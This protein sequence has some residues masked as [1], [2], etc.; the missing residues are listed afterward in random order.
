MENNDTIIKAK[1]LPSLFLA[2]F[3]I[4]FLFA[5]IYCIILPAT[6]T[7]TG[8][9]A[10]YLKIVYLVIGCIGTAFFGYKTTFHVIKLISPPKSVII[11]DEGIFD[12]TIPDGGIA[13]V[14]WDNIADI[15]LFGDKKCDWLGISLRTTKKVFMGLTKSAR[16]EISDNIDAGMPAIIIKAND[17][18]IDIYELRDLIN[19]RLKDINYG[20]QTRVMHNKPSLSQ[21][22]GNANDKATY[23]DDNFII[24]P[25]L[26]DDDEYDVNETTA[27]LDP[28]LP[29][30]EEAQAEDVFE[31]DDSDMI[32]IEDEKE[33]DLEDESEAEEA[34]QEGDD[35]KEE[36]EQKKNEKRFF[37]S[38]RPTKKS[39][40]VK[41]E[42][43]IDD[44]LSALASIHKKEDK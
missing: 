17:I 8:S 22:Y 26:K 16:N 29:N 10:I 27:I 4:I 7:L 37:E 30:E 43:N 24:E 34:I 12:Y 9:Y 35:T 44:I 31:D 42:E 14:S 32:V 18:S 23:Q 25:R 41:E 3:S 1:R 33:V 19:E 28:V 36:T 40:L 15:K 39:D 20:T 5:S 11:T 6:N 21:I 38:K 13:F 2:F